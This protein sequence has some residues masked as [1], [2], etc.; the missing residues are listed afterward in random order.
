ML[1]FHRRFLTGR[2]DVEAEDAETAATRDLGV[3]LAQ[4][5]GSGV[6]RVRERRLAGLLALPV[7]LGEA[8][9][10]QVDL[11]AY[12]HQLGPALAL[13]PQ[14]DLSD[15]AE[16]GGDVL[17]LDAVAARRAHREHARGVREAH[18]RPVD[19]HLERVAR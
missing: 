14:R 6:A 17:A 16:I 18:R 15:G 5:S 13:E 2:F 8:G 19:L 4:R 7:E 12:L 1:R 9:L 3:E 11:S 10:R